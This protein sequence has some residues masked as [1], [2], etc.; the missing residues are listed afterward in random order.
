MFWFTA[1]LLCVLLLGAVQAPA[2]LMLD[3]P[4]GVTRI[5]W[6]NYVQADSIA[7][8]NLDNAICPYPV[9]VAVDP[10]IAAQSTIVPEGPPHDTNCLLRPGDHLYLLWYR[11]KFQVGSVGPFVIPVRV[12]LPAIHS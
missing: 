12:W 9:V 5:N 4:D 1:L 10:A 7:V 6:T 3:A 11:N 2:V 8:A